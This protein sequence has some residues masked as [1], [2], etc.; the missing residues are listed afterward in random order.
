[1]LNTH[2]SPSKAGTLCPPQE[3]EG[4]RTRHHGEPVTG[5]NALTKGNVKHELIPEHSGAGFDCWA[6]A[7]E[8]EVPLK[9]DAERGAL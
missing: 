7:L 2:F 6:P 8:R 9:L 3:G 5:R 1:M 4:P